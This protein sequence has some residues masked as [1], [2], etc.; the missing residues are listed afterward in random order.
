[1]SVLLLQPTYPFVQV[2]VVGGGDATQCATA[3][4]INLSTLSPAWGGPFPLL[5]TRVHP[6]AVLLPDGTVFICGG[7][8]ASGTPP[9]GGRCELYDPVAG[10]LTEMDEL[11]YPRHYHSVA[12]LLP[13]GKVMAA[14]GAGQGGCSLSE[15]NTIE[16]FSPPYLFRGARPVM[17]PLPPLVH[18]GHQF[19]ITTADADEIARVVLVRPM[20]V[21]H[22]TDSEQRLIRLEFVQTAADKLTATMPDGIHPHGLAPRGHYL[23]FILN[24]DGVPSEGQFLFLH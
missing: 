7:M 18:H 17:S 14:G 13:S 4:L 8:E 20:A 9:T 15:F 23:L 16:V 5:E 22:Q 3:Q 11:N 24:V 2:L 21:T 19:E 10:T 6:N 1:M 12:L